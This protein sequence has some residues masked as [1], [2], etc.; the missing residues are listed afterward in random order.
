VSRSQHR[1]CQSEDQPEKA[2]PH[3]LG[4][5]RNGSH[6]QGIRHLRGIRHLAEQG[7]KQAA[8]HRERHECKQEPAYG[9][10]TN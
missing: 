7:R 10:W 2:L 4:E 1:V 9:V 6:V 5:Q 3:N 8:A